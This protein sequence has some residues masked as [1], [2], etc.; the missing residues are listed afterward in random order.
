MNTWSW[1]LESY[2]CWGEKAHA[3]PN[4]TASSATFTTVYSSRPPQSELVREGEGK[5][6]GGGGRRGGEMKESV[7]R[8]KESGRREKGESEGGGGSFYRDVS[9]VQLPFPLW[10]NSEPLVM[11][12]WRVSSSS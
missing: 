1:R 2:T 9:L 11:I 4:H 10:R 8:G 6:E 7:K 12:F 5:S 3:H